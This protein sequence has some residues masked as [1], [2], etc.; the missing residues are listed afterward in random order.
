MSPQNGHIRCEAKSPS[1]GVI[2]SDFLSHAAMKARRLRTRPRNACAREVMAEIQHSQIAA[3]TGQ[4][5]KGNHDRSP[6]AILCKIARFWLRD[7]PR[8]VIVVSRRFG[9]ASPMW[10]IQ[11]SYCRMATPS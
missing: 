1:W 7:M 11:T 9:V 3:Q 10:A 5:G 8:G 2:P 4:C 6:P